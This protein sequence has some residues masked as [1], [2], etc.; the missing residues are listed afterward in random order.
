M[1]IKLRLAGIDALNR[2][3]DRERHFRH[4]ISDG[5][6]A[7]HVIDASPELTS[8]RVLNAEQSAGMGV[9]DLEGIDRSC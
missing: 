8:L 9:V 2:D 4:I 5:E 3:V 1:A 6:G 7:R